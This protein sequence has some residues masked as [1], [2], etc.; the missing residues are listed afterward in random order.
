MNL[1]IIFNGLFKGL[2][3]DIT[4]G[5]NQ[6]MFNRLLAQID[7]GKYANQILQLTILGEM[8]DAEHY[9][10][11]QTIIPKGF[12]TNWPKPH[13]FAFSQEC[14]KVIGYAQECGYNVKDYMTMWFSLNDIQKKKEEDLIKSYLKEIY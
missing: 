8:T 10:M 12:H 1:M 13:I 7:N 5:Y 14:E 6:F 11:L 3:V 4:D 9:L 2:D